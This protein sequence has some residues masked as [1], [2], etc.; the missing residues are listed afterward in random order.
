MKMDKIK[1]YE[2][3]DFVFGCYH[4]YECQEVRHYNYNPVRGNKDVPKA[5]HIFTCAKCGEQCEK[6]TKESGTDVDFF[7]NIRTRDGWCK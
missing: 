7:D 2:L 1:F 3:F 4:D 6:S 5:T